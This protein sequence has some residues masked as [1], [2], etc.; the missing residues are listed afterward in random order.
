MMKLKFREKDLVT[1]IIFTV[2]TNMGLR[3]LIQSTPL[4][5]ANMEK[6]FRSVHHIMMKNP[7]IDLN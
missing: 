5:Q 1:K 4:K 6:F 7:I 2:K 3:Y